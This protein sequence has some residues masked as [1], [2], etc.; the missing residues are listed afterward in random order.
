MTERTLISSFVI[1]KET[2]KAFVVRK[3]QV[4]RVICHEG[5][6]TAD[7]NAWVLDN[8]EEY[9]AAGRTRF[10]T[11]CHPRK[12]DYLYTNPGRDRKMWQII[13]DTVKHTVSENGATAHDVLYPRCSKIVFS[14]P[15]GIEDHGSC[16]DSLAAAI[17]PFGLGPDRTHDTLNIFMKTGVDAAGNLF[18]EPPDAVKG[19]YCDLL[20]LIDSLVA[21]S[22]CPAGDIH[23]TN[24]YENKALKIEIYE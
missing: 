8:H 18:I 11:G 6:Q 17:A 7:F 10:F 23:A 1:P 22:S 5:P 14:E 20:C 3:G 9:F 13:E 24:G 15:F 21:I 19:D 4:M 2:A 12:G 16:Q